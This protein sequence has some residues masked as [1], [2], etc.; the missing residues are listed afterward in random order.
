MQ[1]EIHRAYKRRLAREKKKQEAIDLAPSKALQPKSR[2][3]RYDNMKSAMAEE[4]VIALA[5]RE[6]AL[7]D[8][9]AELKA[10]EFSAPLLGKVFGQ[11]QSRHA[12]GLEVSL[13]VLEELTSEEASHVAMIFQ[14]QQGDADAFGLANKKALQG[15]RGQQK[16]SCGDEHPQE[17]RAEVVPGGE[18][19][20]HKIPPFLSS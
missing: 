6:P 18:L 16:Q 20:G 8:H 10:Q 1:E 3:I 14:R 2:T 11:L 12:Q 17:H 7:L 19:D 4:G 5:L 13:A 15:D 9:A